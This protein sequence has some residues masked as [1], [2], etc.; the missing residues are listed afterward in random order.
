MVTTQDGVAAARSGDLD[1]D[2]SSVLQTT[3]SGPGEGSFFWKISSEESDRL[4]FLID[5]DDAAHVSGEVGWAQQ[6]FSVPSGSHTL[7]WRFQ[8]NYNVTQGSDAGWIDP[9]SF[10]ELR[11]AMLEPVVSGSS[12]AVSVASLAGKNY[13]LEYKVNLDDP[14]W[15]PLPSVP[16][17]GSPLVLTD[18]DSTNVHRFYRVRIE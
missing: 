5:G 17:T 18:S 3:V 7:T 16:G 6:T 15:T 8:K 9:F 12:F 11:V 14:E 4:S 13:I 10:E 2:Q 1:D